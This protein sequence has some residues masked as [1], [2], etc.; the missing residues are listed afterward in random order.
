MTDSVSAVP[1]D[2][3]RSWSW[4]WMGLAVSVT[5]T[6]IGVAG[7]V[8]AFLIGIVVWGNDWPVMW[9]MPIL[10]YVWWIAVASGGTFVSA[11]FFLVRVEWRTAINRLAET[12]TLCAAVC[13][14]IYPILHL[15]RPYFAYWLFP[16]PN[17]MTL[18]PQWKSPLLWD[19]MALLT[20][21]VASI[22][23]W[24]L[25][26]IP[27][28]ATM[29]DRAKSRAAQLAYGVF[30]LGWRGTAPQWRHLKAT[31]GVFAAIMAPVVVSIHSVVG[32]DFAGAATPGWHSTEYPPFFVFGALWSGL[33][34]VTL[35]VLALRRPLRF[36]ALMTERHLRV[37]GKL[38]LTSGLLMSYAYIMDA[39]DPFY[40]GEAADRVQFISR[41]AG[42]YAPVYWGM[43]TCNCV[44]PLILC[45][46][47]ARR[48]HAVLAV[49]CVG[50]IVGMWLERYNIVVLTLMRTH[51]PSAWG[52]YAPTLCDWMI[53]GGTLGLFATGLLLAI[54]AVPLVSMFEMR[55]MLAE[56]RQA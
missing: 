13:A 50:S 38:L 36:D 30:A 55:E 28:L 35:L 42:P 49:V 53:F 34:T 27:D 43:I 39:F 52:F 10:A 23:F 11:F 40:S 33:A 37:L 6:A 5:A 51:L 16:Y 19:F 31:Y 29:R 45:W 32:L 21:V 24:Y 20:Y 22:L 18:W 41:V 8:W 47:R 44:L 56:R 25:G 15:G 1:L 54:R 2:P 26:L 9:G 4:W 14:G 3:R 7:I 48:S 17:S 12:M 46:G